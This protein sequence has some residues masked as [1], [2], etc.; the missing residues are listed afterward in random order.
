M[1][2][3]LFLLGLATALGFNNAQAVDWNWKGDIRYRYQSEI[4]QD[5]EHSRDRH[6]I[7]VRFGVTPWINE[8]L[9][10]G[11]RLA[12]GNDSDPISRN[13]TLENGFSAKN[14]MLD[15]AY[16]NYHPMFLNGDVNILLGK[17]D[18][19]KTL[20]IEK[21]LVWDGDLTLEGAT[22]QYGKDTDGKQKSGFGAIAGWYSLDEDKAKSDPYLLAF[23]GAYKGEVS[24]LGF[25]LGV[26]YYDFVHFD[27]D[28]DKDNDGK[29][30]IL[31]FTPVF[32]YT[33]KD[34][35]IVEFFGSLGGDITETVPWKLYGQYAFNTAS[36]SSINYAIDNNARD[37]YLIG[38]K[39]GKAKNPGQL[40][41]SAEYVHIEEDAVTIFT[42]SDRNAGRSTNLE[43]FKLSTTYHLV[44]NMT[45]GATYMNFQ[46]I[47]G[48]KKDQTQHLLQADVVVKF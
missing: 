16:I 23:Q 26:G 17:R 48:S 40:E 20:F 29:V 11:L 3:T 32:D 34:F 43:G 36:N 6:R 7:R 2:K 4:K 15:E 21:D 38:L 5:N 27:L 28:N 47:D 18:I 35:N 22:L 14:I 37:A 33:G 1:K 45:V 39:I 46:D 30:N 44:Q 12:T 41:G 13:Q 24:D 10:A 9:S 42:D 8:E 25:D 31:G 19:A